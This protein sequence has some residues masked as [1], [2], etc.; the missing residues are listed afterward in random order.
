MNFAAP[1][2]QFAGF[3]STARRPISFDPGIAGIKYAKVRLIK[4]LCT[5]ISLPGINNVPL[6]QK[7]HKKYDNI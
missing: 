2:C 7:P 5:M 6:N 3:S 4:I 1:R